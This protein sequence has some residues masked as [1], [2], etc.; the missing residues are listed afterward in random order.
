MEIDFIATEPHF[1][2]HLSPVWLALTPSSRGKFY[3]NRVIAAR[4]APLG[5][6]VCERFPSRQQI[7]TVTASFG[8]YKVARRCGQR[9][10]IFCEHG[11]GQSYNGDNPSYAGASRRSGV[12][13]F[14]CPNIFVAD[15]N[16]R[17]NVPCRIVGTPKLDRWASYSLVNG[18]KPIV[19]ISFHW[20]CRVCPE[21]RSAFKFYEVVL[22]E[23]GKSTEFRLVGHAHPRAFTQGRVRRF[24]RESRIESWPE[25][26]RV[27][28]EASLY[29][30]DNTSTL[31]EFAATGRPVV[32]L[33][34]PHYRR[35]V[36][37]G[38]RFWEFADVGLNCDTP[39]ALK[40]TILRALDDPPGVAARREEISRLLYPHLGEAAVKAAKEIETFASAT[41]V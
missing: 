17:H 22:C 11:T 9:P 24:F 37:H 7:L 3:G 16:S 12:V 23:L 28:D 31:F 18:E 34:C 15:A 29:V 10:V 36:S 8:D 14:L 38:L 32:V 6:E 20:D 40:D 27:L 21:T 26:S 4:G 2:D 39:D 25:F 1:F 35:E 33:N 13:L 5:I 19:C 30:A 41:A